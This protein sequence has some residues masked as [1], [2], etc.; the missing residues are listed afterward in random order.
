MARFTLSVACGGRSVDVD[1]ANTN[2]G[3]GGTTSVD[4]STRTVVD[5]SVDEFWADDTRLYWQTHASSLQG[6][7][8]ND[9]SHT[10][11]SYGTNGT[12]SF[13]IGDEDVYWVAAGVNETLFYTCPKT[14]CSGSARTVLRDPN[15]VPQTLSADGDYFYWSSAF[16]IYRCPSAG[17]GATPE[18][19][20]ANHT[21]GAP[22]TFQDENAYWPIP[23]SSDSGDAGAAG[24][25]APSGVLY[26]PKDG[27]APVKVLSL[28]E[29]SDSSQSPNTN[30]YSYN[31][32]AFDS[33]RVYWIDASARILSCPLEGCPEPGTV[34]LAS[35]SANRFRLSV[36][37]VGLY[38]FEMAP[39]IN[40]AGVCGNGGALHFCAFDQCAAGESTVLANAVYE[41]ALGGPYVYFTKQMDDCNQGAI[42]RMPKPTP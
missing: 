4:R 26:A 7:L 25:G 29:D 13:A 15:G 12:Y 10:T 40:V 35:S 22:L 1:R 23:T 39:S 31:S 3:S 36:D 18:V 28:R 34:E 20:A 16:D 19:V 8:Q 17:C 38:W 37:S 27:S 14:G 41:Y 2:G 32:F 24:S 5:A 30:Y 6:C 33:Q 42:Q 21:I 11:V 9:C